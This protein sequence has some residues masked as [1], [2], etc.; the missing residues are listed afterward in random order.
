[1]PGEFLIKLVR[2]LL[3]SLKV[4][5]GEDYMSI[6][7]SQKKAGDQPAGLTVTT[8]NQEGSGV[9]N[10]PAALST[11]KAFRVIIRLGSPRPQCTTSTFERLLPGGRQ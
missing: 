10:L 11:R 2:K 4:S 1:M 9:H 7:L 8:Q 3:G 6:T 5:P